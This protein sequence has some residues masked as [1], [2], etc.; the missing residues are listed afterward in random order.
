MYIC[1]IFQ[2][3]YFTSRFLQI[4]Y[5]L[6]YFFYKTFEISLKISFPKMLKKLSETYLPQNMYVVHMQFK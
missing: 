4:N 3:I 6:N 2:H 5:K 1:V